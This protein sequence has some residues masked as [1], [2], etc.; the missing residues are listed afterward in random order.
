MGLKEIISGATNAEGKY[1]DV[2][3]PKNTSI[4][5]SPEGDPPIRVLTTIAGVV[6]AGATVFRFWRTK[7]PGRRKLQRELEA[8]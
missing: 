2:Y 1:D 5:G 8:D 6:L 7:G 3:I 4:W